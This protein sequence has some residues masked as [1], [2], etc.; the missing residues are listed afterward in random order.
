MYAAKLAVSPAPFDLDD[1]DEHT[2]PGDDVCWTATAYSFLDGEAN[3]VEGDVVIRQREEETI[4]QVTESTITTQEVEQ[5]NIYDGHYVLDPEGWMGVDSSDVMNAVEEF[6]LR[7]GTADR[8]HGGL[9]PA[10]IDLDAF[11]QAINGPGT[12]FWH[13]GWSEQEGDDDEQFL[14]EAKGEGDTEVD[15]DYLGATATYH[16]DA[17]LSDKPPGAAYNQIGF[18]IRQDGTRYR[19]VVAASGWVALYDTE[20]AADYGRFVREHVLQHTHGIEHTQITL[21][22]AADGVDA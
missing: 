7:F 18:R 14:A 4:P 10:R 15:H 17:F 5:Q 9:E 19:G 2:V 13:V 21:D 6:G 1:F 22:E 16:D 3:I 20:T 11:A 8:L 12:Y